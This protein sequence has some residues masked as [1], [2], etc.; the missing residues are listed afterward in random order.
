MTEETLM[1]QVYSLYEGDVDDWTTTGSDYLAARRYGNAAIIMWQNYDNTKWRELF[2]TLTGAS[3]GDKTITTAVFTYDAP[4]D[5]LWLAS[6]VRTVNAGVSTYYTPKGSEK[7]SILDDTTGKWCYI[8]GNQADGFVVNFN[9][10]L[11]LTTGDTL[12]YEYYKKATEFTVPTTVPEMSNP[13]FI[14]HYILWRL[15][16]NDGEDPKASEEF[17]IAQQMLEQMRVD[18]MA[19]YTDVPHNPGDDIGFGE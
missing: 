18:N 19:G 13:Y 3:D 1:D 17:Q 15:Y 10:D 12:V 7:I 6:F 2:S 16:K 14:V 9:P 5:F 11:T 4:T 8:T